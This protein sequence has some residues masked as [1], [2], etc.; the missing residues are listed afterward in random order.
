MNII[1]IGM[2]HTTAPVEVREKY[3]F[4]EEELPKIL[5]ELKNVEGV[6][7]CIILSTCN[8][9]ELHVLM[10]G[11]DPVEITNFLLKKNKLPESESNN[12]QDYL[13]TFRNG[14][15]LEHL[16]KVSSGLDSMV[17]GEPQIFGQVKD[18]YRLAVDA[19]TAGSVFQS[20][21]PQIF[22]VVKRIRSSTNIGQSNV[23]VSYVAV[24]LARDIFNDIQGKNV[25]ILGAGEMGELT[26]R[27]LLNHGAKRV[28]VTNR[29]FE[30]A[31][32][33]AET[34]NGIPIMF[35]ELFEYLPRVD[36][37]ISSIS[38]EQYIINREELVD[39]LTLRNG[40]PLIIIDISVPRTVN[41][42]VAGLDEVHLY[43]IDDLKSVAE[44]NLSLRADEARR[45]DQIIKNRAPIILSKLN[46]QD[47]V[48]AIISLK[49]A[50]EDIRQQGYEKFI[51]SLDVPDSQKDLI[52]SF[53]KSMTK[54]IVHQAITKMRE[55]MNTIKY[56]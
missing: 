11:E 49:N 21:F 33:L 52:E 14:E 56:K 27:N 53:S 31:V 4:K 42:D 39:V 5:Q 26:V 32:R 15:A 46:T 12:F 1:I 29:T 16:C 23:S 41:P 6:M 40:N 51:N 37:V 10:L 20:L 43:N 8:R 24:N 55:Y 44:S 28:F 13:Y 2:N 17:L 36:I 9:V 22:S 18:A 3:S 54:Q 45:A 25:M 35:Y 19:G 30:K 50:A 34:F 47:I 48:P 7:E 38:A